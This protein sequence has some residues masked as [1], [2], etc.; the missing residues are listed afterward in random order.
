MKARKGKAHYTEVKK[1]NGNTED[2]LKNLE[3][4]LKNEIYYVTRNDYKKETIID[5]GKEREILKLP[6]YPHRIVQWALMNVLEDIM[7][8]NLIYDTYASIKGRGIHVAVRRFRNSLKDKETTK[9]CLKMDVKKFYPNIDNAILYS[10]LKKKFKD[11]QLLRLLKIIIFSTG[12]KGQPIGSLWSQFAGNFYLSELDHWLKEEK[13]IKHYFRY[14]DDMVILHNDKEFLHELRVEIERFLEEKLK[15]KL[16][17]NWQVFPVDVRGVDFLG[18]RFFRDY[19]LLRK[20]TV[21]NFK[22]KIKKIK[23]KETLSYSD[24]C[25]LNSY[26]GWMKYC[27][28]FRLTEKYIYPLDG[29]EYISEGGGVDILKIK[30]ENNVKL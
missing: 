23:N 13:R 5:R 10:L 12:G 18:Y 21:K 29:K 9:Y 7:I 11:L 4:L 3:F 26:R 24:V 8:K 20:R 14:C 27:N 15:V 19:I 17:E 2:Y 16:K 28:S 1:V 25:S 30:E 6:Y 22:K